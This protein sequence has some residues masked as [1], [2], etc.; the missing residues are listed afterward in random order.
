VSAIAPELTCLAAMDVGLNSS[1]A[2][3]ASPEVPFW[4]SPLA[5]RTV[6]WLP[7]VSTLLR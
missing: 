4:I 6:S 1:S 5:T 7:L 3:I 2:A